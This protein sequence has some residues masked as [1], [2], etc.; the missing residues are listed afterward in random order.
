MAADRGPFDRS[1]QHRRERDGERARLV[2]RRAGPPRAPRRARPARGDALHDS[3]SDHQRRLQG[4]RHRSRVPEDPPRLEPCLR[5]GA[6]RGPDTSE[7]SG[8]PARRGPGRRAPVP[9]HPGEPASVRRHHRRRCQWRARSPFISPRPASATSSCSSDGHWR[10]AVRADRSASSASSIRRK[11]PARWWCARSACSSASAK[12]SAATGLRRVR[13]ADRRV[14]G[15]AAGSSKRPSRSS[16]LSAF[17]PRCWSRAISSASSRGSIPRISA[18]S[19]T[20]PTRATAIPP[21]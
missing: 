13:R 8:T 15:D 10:P 3:V 21:R 19:F 2:R 17:A 5:A 11:R 12:R 9:P 20:S 14:G 18:R 4:R 7:R 16:G 1:R 6:R